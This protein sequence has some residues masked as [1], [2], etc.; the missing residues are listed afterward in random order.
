MGNTT[1]QRGKKHLADD[2]SGNSLSV[3]PRQTEKRRH[4]VQQGKH[5]DSAAEAKES[6]KKTANGTQRCHGSNER[7]AH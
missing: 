6:G 4:V 3:K 5:E 2:D 1:D 7:A